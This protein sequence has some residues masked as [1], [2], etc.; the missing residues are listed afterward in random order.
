MEK[1][2]PKVYVLYDS[3]YMQFL[4]EQ[5]WRNEEQISGWKDLRRGREMGVAIQGNMN[6]PCGDGNVLYGDCLNVNIPM[7]ILHYSFASCYHWGKLD[8]GYT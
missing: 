8:K 6:N 4:K 1:P 5:T 3:I 7:I 2:V